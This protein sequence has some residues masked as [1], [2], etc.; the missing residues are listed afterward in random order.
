MDDFC[1]D[2]TETLKPSSPAAA[3]ATCVS[4]GTAGEVIHNYK[5]DIDI[6]LSNPLSCREGVPKNIIFFT[7]VSP[8]LL[9]FSAKVR[10]CTLYIKLSFE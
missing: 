5:A 10:L 8:R 4:K 3:L 2:L 7:L 1:N 6:Q 9:C